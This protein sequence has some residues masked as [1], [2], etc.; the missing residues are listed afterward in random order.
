MTMIFIKFIPALI[1]LFGQ[2][3]QEPNFGAFVVDDKISIGYGLAI[4]DVDG[5]AKPD[6]LLADKRQFVWYRNGDWKRH[7]M[8]SDLTESDNVCIAARDIDGDGL[9]EVAVGAQWNPRE[10]SDPEKSGAVFYLERP[11]DPTQLWDPVQLPHEPTTHR[12]KWVK[13]DKTNYQLVVV[14]LHGRGNQN[15]EGAGVK[16]MGYEM[17]SAPGKNWKLHTIDQSMHLTHNFD[18]VEKDGKEWVLLGGKEGLK[19]YSF[20]GKEWIS[21][22]S[23]L[24]EGDPFGEVRDGT[25]R[26]SM[27]IVGIQPMHG[28]KL[29]IYLEDMTERK[30]LT[31]DLQQGHAIATA[32]LLNLG[33]DQIIVGWR[34]P[35]ASGEVGIKIFIPKD[36]LGSEWTN[37]WIDEKGIATED[38]LVADLNNDGKQDIVAA[39]RATRNLKIYWNRN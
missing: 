23:W 20:D 32:D 12:M 14:P 13:V 1:L 34:S 24:I 15:G 5:D 6:I 9:V 2:E 30:V 3:Q 39:G 33:L 27:M 21:P 35:N 11:A 8:I 7:V 10:T 17:S 31:D 4:G 36:R 25:L 16:I 26:E 19:Q 18:I 37:Y 29:V 28:D 22:E 38:L